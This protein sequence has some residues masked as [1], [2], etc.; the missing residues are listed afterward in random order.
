MDEWCRILLVGIIVFV[1]HTLEGIT[2]FG[3]TIL[4]LP[5][6]AMLL[7]I[8]V[9]V[10]VMVV[11]AWL[12]AGYIVIVSWKKIVWKEY[13]F[14][15][16]H[17]GIGLPVGLILFQYLSPDYL[18]LFLAVFMVGVG[19]HGFFQIMKS[20]ADHEKQLPPSLKN[21]VMRSILFVG[22]TVHGAFASGGPF[23]VIYA[24]KTLSDKSVFRVSLCLLWFTMNTVMIGQYTLNGNVWNPEIGKIL[25]WAF[26]FL[27]TGM[28]LGDFLHHYVNE[29]YFRL[30][31]YGALVASGSILVFDVVKNTLF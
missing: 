29:Y 25:L 12:L 11:L 2:G 20:S 13:F 31:V 3:C 7:G 4:A 14:I 1:T 30:T 6:I 28:F 18:K 27:V 26:P 21:W 9:A 17:V 5:F 22:G 15:V 16:C 24:S 19:I 23:V 8:K 10:P